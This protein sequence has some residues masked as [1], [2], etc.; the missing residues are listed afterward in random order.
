MNSKLTTFCIYLLLSTLLA[1]CWDQVQ[2]EERGF[3]VGVGIDI[4]RTKKTEQQA[5]QEAPDKPPVKE[6]FLVT[7]QFVVPGGL[8][9]GGQGSGGG[10]NTANEAFHNLVSEGDSLF[11]I[12]RELAS[13][14]SR[15]PFYQHMKILIVSEEVA[16]TKDGFARALDF[17]LRDPDSR[18]S[19]KVFIS[20]GLAKEVLEVKPKTEKLP[21]IYVNSVAENNIKNARM[22]PAVRLGD[23]HE[24][25]L[26]PYSFVVPRI[27]PEEQ[28]VK[29]AGAAVF[30]HDNQ[31][32]GFL[33]E[34]ETEGLNFL[35][36]NI[37][38][39]MLK[40]KFKNNLVSMNI[41]GIKHGI[42]ADLRDRQHMKFTI[43]I[44]CEGTL[45]E[46]YATMDY[47]NHMAMEKLEQVFAEE[48]ERMSYDTIRKVHN[49]MK[50]DVIKLGSYLKQHHFSLWKKIRQDWET[51]Q[52]LYE[53]SEII[54]QAKVYLR[55]IGAINRTER[56]NN[57]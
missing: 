25:L 48:I 40:G 49:Q 30:A 42:K 18:R 11:E 23:V 27:R 31:L 54:V 39:G 46:S 44:E 1:G 43:E 20:K 52:H 14:T 33:G 15:A 17:Y 55:N 41:Q 4:P 37:N 47:L 38:G 8:V 9:S 19:S 16:R 57:R 10:Q 22:L 26:S 3:V 45:A 5:K 32:M 51:G 13:R 56:Q 7:H 24:E 12:S 36:G 28:E 35:T 34:E 2:I 21:A 6:R 53:K 50:V 29:L